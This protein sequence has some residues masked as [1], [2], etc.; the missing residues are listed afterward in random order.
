VGYR[1]RTPIFGGNPLPGGAQAVRIDLA[2]NEVDRAALFGSDVVLPRSHIDDIHF[3]ADHAYLTDA[4]R[5]G[6]IVLDL[7]D[8]S[9]RRVLSEERALTAPANRDVDGA[10]TTIVAS[11]ELHWVDAMFIDANHTL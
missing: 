8:G 1:Y 2:T 9:A 10:V 3:N 4:G 6:L 11:P 5:P 7:C